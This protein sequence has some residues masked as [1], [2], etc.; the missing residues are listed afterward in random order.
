MRTRLIGLVLVVASVSSLGQV[1]QATSLFEQGRYEEAKKMLTPLH[2]DPQA[3]SLLGRIA[4]AEGDSENAVSLLEKAIEKKPNIAEYYFHLG[5][6]YGDLA[7][8]AS[9]FRQPGYALKTK[10]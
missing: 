8:H 9:F 4:I 2:D 1:P 3:L 10:N 6:A 7:Q 5:D